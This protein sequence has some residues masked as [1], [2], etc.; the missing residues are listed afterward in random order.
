MTVTYER[1]GEIARITLARG[2]ARNAMNRGMYAATNA[3]FRRFHED[4]EANVAIFSSN[5]ADAFCAGVDL[6]D[7]H[8]ALTVEGLT[9]ADLAP[10]YSIF[11]EEPGALRKPV[12][13]AINGH[14]VGEGLVMAM[15][16]DI[17]VAADDA[18]FSLP[19]AKVGVPAINGTIRAVQIAGHGAAMEL[20]LT[21]ES[22]D[23][24]W[25]KTA[26]L[27][28]TVV[29]A[30]DLSDTVERLAEAIAGNSAAAIRIMRELGE[31][32]LEESFVD[33]VSYGLELR[34]EL[35]SVDMVKRQAEFVARSKD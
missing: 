3:A 1:S 30:C 10:Q 28:N 4:S 26:G 23:A 5:D 22:R 17:R 15:F 20:L 9:L 29:P 16:C 6:K 24:S 12:I 27:V 2:G 7:V 18:L 11:F 34:S 21:G 19:E 32:A 13:A 14:C 33:L 8:H 35:E 25:A 31:R